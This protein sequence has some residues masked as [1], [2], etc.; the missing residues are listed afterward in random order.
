[1]S[2]FGENTYVQRIYSFEELLHHLATVGPVALSIKGD[3]GRY[4]TNGHLL[5]VSGYEIT[6]SGRNILVHDPNLP[7][8]EYKYSESIFNRITRNVI[9]VMEAKK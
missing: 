5:V 6:P 1:M 7:E 2:A 8:V 9:Y 4:Y 3:T